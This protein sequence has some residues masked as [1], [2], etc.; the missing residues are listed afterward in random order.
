M[1]NI[2][3][4]DNDDMVASYIMFDPL[5]RWMVDTDYEK[6]FIEFEVVRREGFGSKVDVDRYFG[7]NAVY[8]W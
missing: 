4:E 8:E 5:G 6:R 2:V 1:E 3:F 7:R